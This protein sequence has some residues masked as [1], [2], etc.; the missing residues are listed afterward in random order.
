MMRRL[1]TPTWKKDGRMTTYVIPERLLTEMAAVHSPKGRTRWVVSA[2]HAFADYNET[3]RNGMLLSDL[4]AKS[5]KHMKGLPLRLSGE[6]QA[7]L[8][9][10]LTS[11][12]RSYPEYDL[13]NSGIVRMA[14]IFYLRHHEGRMLADSTNM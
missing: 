6:T 12:R 13:D 1:L 8:R 5:T 2:I 3:E 11:F 9:H 10:M 7:E 4:R 14:I